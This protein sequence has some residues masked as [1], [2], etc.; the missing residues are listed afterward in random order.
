MTICRRGRREPSIGLL[1]D[2]RELDM[3][4]QVKLAVQLALLRISMSC[5]RIE[6][7]AQRLKTR[8]DLARLTDLMRR[9]NGLT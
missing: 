7:I 4:P 3:N 9:K 6:A 1:P 5:A 8:P 2:R